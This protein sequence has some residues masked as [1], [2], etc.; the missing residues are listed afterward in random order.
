M[1]FK[2]NQKNLVNTN[3]FRQPVPSKLFGD[4]DHLTSQRV[5]HDCGDPGSTRSRKRIKSPSTPPSPS[6]TS[7]PPMSSTC[8]FWVKKDPVQQVGGAVGAATKEGKPRRHVIP[9]VCDDLNTVAAPDHLHRTCF[10]NSNVDDVVL[11]FPA[12]CHSRLQS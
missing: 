7:R 4:G 10:A 2:L 5:Q 9:A 12:V 3:P 8:G 1:Q 6:K 11:L